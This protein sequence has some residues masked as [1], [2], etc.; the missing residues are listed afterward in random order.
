[1]SPGELLGQEV[2]VV[3]ICWLAEGGVTWVVVVVAAVVVVAIV[4][5]RGGNSQVP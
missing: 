5:P 4:V 1:M 3:C 2:W